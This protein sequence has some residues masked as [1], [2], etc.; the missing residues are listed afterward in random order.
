MIQMQLPT[1]VGT[2]SEQH[3]TQM[4]LEMVDRLK[5]S[6]EIE[7][8]LFSQIDIQLPALTHQD[9]YRWRRRQGVALSERENLA[10][11]LTKIS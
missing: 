3:S 9:H 11:A 6:G 4:D 8:Y 2:T 7:L 5:S 1:L 10:C